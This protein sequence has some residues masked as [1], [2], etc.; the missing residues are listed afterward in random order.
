MFWPA[1]A[2]LSLALSGE[3]QIMVLTAVVNG[4]SPDRVQCSLIRKS[5]LKI[6]TTRAFKLSNCFIIVVSGCR[7]DPGKSVDE[8]VQREEPWRGNT[9]SRLPGLEA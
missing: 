6:S 9:A 8:V 1:V 2:A 4:Y 5:L 7:S 3:H